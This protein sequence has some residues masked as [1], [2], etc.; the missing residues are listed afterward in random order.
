M[1]CA[2]RL[3][4]IAYAV[5]GTSSVAPSCGLVIV[6]LQYA[7]VH[8]FD[9]SQ[10]SRFKFFCFDLSKHGMLFTAESVVSRNPIEEHHEK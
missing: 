10:G 2:G 5:Q 9:L 8:V 1:F 6:I 7:A 4:N 3:S